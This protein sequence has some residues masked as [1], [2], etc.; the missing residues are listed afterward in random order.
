[1]NLLSIIGKPGPPSSSPPKPNG[2]SSEGPNGQGNQGGCKTV[3]C[4]FI[5]PIKNVLLAFTASTKKPNNNNGQ[6]PGPQNG[7]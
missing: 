4:N 7:F 1:M 6:R 5:S 2:S 3:L